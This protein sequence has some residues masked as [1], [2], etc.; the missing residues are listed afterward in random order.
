MDD[1]RL[2]NIERQMTE[3]GQLLQKVANALLGNLELNSVGL[4]EEQR[5]L[6]RQVESLNKQTSTQQITIESQTQ[7]ITSL[8][9]FRGSVKRIV[10]LIA[11]AI[12][13]LFEI[14]KGIT[15]VIY[16]YVTKAS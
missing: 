3:Q 5:N 6:R 13:F 1:Q 9:E 11:F 10:A 2:S 4:I 16:H 14:V 7:E 12:P 15:Y 8:K